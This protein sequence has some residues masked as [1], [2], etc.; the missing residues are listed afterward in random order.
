MVIPEDMEQCR[1]I[2]KETESLEKVKLFLVHCKGTEVSL[3]PTHN[4]RLTPNFPE[5]CAAHRKWKVCQNKQCGLKLC[6]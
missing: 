2:R 4:L 6:G 1:R 5:S 3:Q